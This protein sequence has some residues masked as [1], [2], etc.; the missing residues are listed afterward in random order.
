MKYA[1]SKMKITII[2]LMILPL[3]FFFSSESSAQLTA[4]A[5]HDHI[6][7]DFFY[8]GSTVG[9]SGISDPGVDLV[10]KLTSAD[11]HQLLKKKGKVAG[12]LWMN[13]GEIGLEH[14]PNVYFLHSTK[15]IEDILSRNEMDKYGIGYQ[16][17]E[18]RLEMTPAVSKEEKTKW[19]NEFIK[20]KE[21]SNL[22]AVS[23][24][25]ISIKEKDGGQDYY[26]STKW[27]HQA[28]PSK[29]LVTV[30]AIKGKKVIET[31]TADVLVEQT[32]M[33]KT[34]ADMAKNKGAFYGIISIAAALGAG[35]GVGMIFRKSGGAH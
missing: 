27:P 13:V 29:Y 11:G 22:Y 24:G 31:A 6:K 28:P 32:G 2:F 8:H 10:I 34:I 33:V 30:Y 35:F 16:A 21:S 23:S 19:F 1:E 26:I 15:N 7:I 12:L 14:V 3:L 25:K 20:F 9:V 18:R 4:K 5:N 17:I